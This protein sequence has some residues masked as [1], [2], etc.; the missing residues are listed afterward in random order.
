MD[1]DAVT[2]FP[3]PSRA[4]ACCNSASSIQASDTSSTPSFLPSSY[5]QQEA[6]L[7][8][9]DHESIGR[10]LLTPN[11]SSDEDDSSSYKP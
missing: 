1:Q 9:S 11:D 6:A 3:L 4:T 8:I 2:L 10:C 7:V 5:L